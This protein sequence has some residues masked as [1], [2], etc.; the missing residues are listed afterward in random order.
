MRKPVLLIGNNSETFVERSEVPRNESWIDE[1]KVLLGR[2]YGAG[3]NFPIKVYNHPRVARPGTAC[4]ETYLVIGR[5]NSE[6]L[7]RKFE[8]YLRTRFVRFLV[9]LRKNT[10]D[11]YSERFQFVPDLPMTQ[12]WTDRELYKKYKLTKDEIEFIESMI[13]PM[14]GDDE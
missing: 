7:A 9:S 14:E 8:G 3:G 11:I 4:T 12:D 5:F 1:W 6:R 13:R 10:Q 2:A